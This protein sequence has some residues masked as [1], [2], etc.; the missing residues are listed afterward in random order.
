MI[1]KRPMN[2]NLPS[3]PLKPQLR[4][5]FPSPPPLNPEWYLYTDLPLPMQRVIPGLFSE[6]QAA[7]QPLNVLMN[8]PLGGTTWSDRSPESQSG[9]RTDSSR[10]RWWAGLRIEEVE[11]SADEAPIGVRLVV[12][13]N[14][15]VDIFEEKSAKNDGDLN[16]SFSRLGCE[17]FP[18]FLSS[19]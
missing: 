10:D 11:W 17:W 9:T 4:L 19:R 8:L 13:L 16:F 14:A 3:S 18:C 7:N 2:T 1:T 12:D 6:L 15:E 5:L